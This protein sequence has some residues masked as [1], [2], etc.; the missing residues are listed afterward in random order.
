MPTE[1]IKATYAW[2][3]K[4]GFMSNLISLTPEETKIEARGKAD[5]AAAGSWVID[6][7]TTRERAREIWQGIEDGDPA[8]LDSLPALCLGEWADDPSWEDILD[9]EDIEADDDTADDLWRTYEDAWHEG[10]IDRVTR[11][12]RLAMPMRISLSLSD[13]DDGSV[14]VYCEDQEQ[15]KHD[16]SI[17]GSCWEYPK[18]MN[19][20]YASILAR[21]GLVAELT[22][23]GYDVD[24]SEYS[25]PDG[26][27]LAYW[28]YRAE[29][30]NAGED[31]LDRFAWLIASAQPD[32]SE[33]V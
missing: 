25:D 28:S 5:G 20:A 16:Q 22:R 15:A 12:A 6:G 30:E 17:A 3:R 33:G 26:E 29:C 14:T 21:P 24:D 19:V 2:L 23:E 10:M 11:D 9:D 1:N 32:S 27:D 7:N 8:I 31:P 18:D 13:D 4:E